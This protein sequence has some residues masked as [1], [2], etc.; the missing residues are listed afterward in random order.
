[1]PTLIFT[2]ELWIEFLNFVI[3]SL[4]TDEREF[5]L[6]PPGCSG[7]RKIYLDALRLTL[8]SFFARIL[9]NR[10][11]VRSVFFSLS[12]SRIACREVVRIFFVEALITRKRSVGYRLKQAE[13]RMLEK[14]FV[15]K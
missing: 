1:M 11:R 14:Q 7:H 5:R 3:S 9:S 15:K 8:C 13:K 10:Y 2:A 12:L 6:S 4:R